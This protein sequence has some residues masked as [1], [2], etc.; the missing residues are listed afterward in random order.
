M[1]KIN[2]IKNKFIVIIGLVIFSCFYIFE[3]NF[4]S[5]AQN[6]QDGKKE[7]IKSQ[8]DDNNKE[9]KKLEQEIKDYNDKVKDKRSD[10][11]T[12][13]SAIQDLEYRKDNLKKEIGVTDY[14]IINTKYTISNTE[15]KILDLDSKLGKLKLGLEKSFKDMQYLDK[16]KSSEAFVLLAGD[17][18]GEVFDKYNQ[19]SKFKNSI[20]ENMNVFLNTKN[21]LKEI[22]LSY[23]KEVKNLENL[24]DDLSDKKLLTDQAQK[25]KDKLLLETKK[26]ESNFQ[27]IISQRKKQKTELEKEVLDFESKLKALVDKSKLPKNT[28][29][30]L[31]YPV[32]NVKITQYFGNTP[33]ASQNPQVYNGSGHNGVDFA[34]PVGTALYSAADGVVMGSGNTDDSCKGASYGG[35][36]LIKHNNGLSTL[37]AHMS[38]IS[39]YA[40]QQVTTG[41]KIGLS[42]NTGY[43]TG[44]HLHFTVYASEAVR[45]SGPTEYKSRACGTYMI[46]PLAPRNGYLNPLTYF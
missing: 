30:V 31:A 12:L 38:S 9:I 42:G 40:G 25:E 32:K 20:D 1:S 27:K 23:K 5:Y 7:E 2:N 33:F 36:V 8:I 44:P 37:Y 39:S 29:G 24:Q 22:N 10:A 43:S 45:I 28:G 34:V 3:N 11:A 18:F 16:L 35:W 4:L 19:T 6:T 26:D 41:Q 21:S 14:K 46:M 17:N 13:K 15:K